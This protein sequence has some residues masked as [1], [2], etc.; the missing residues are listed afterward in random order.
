MIGHGVKT[1]AQ[2][3]LTGAMLN[4]HKPVK[5]GFFTACKYVL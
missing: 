3:S 1:V 4:N 5:S 2:E